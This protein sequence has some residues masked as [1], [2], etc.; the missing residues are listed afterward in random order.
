METQKARTKIEQY[1]EISKAVNS[2]PNFEML[3]GTGKTIYYRVILPESPEP[4]WILQRRSNT[5][6][7]TIWTTCLTGGANDLVNLFD[8][9]NRR[10][11]INK[12]NENP[13]TWNRFVDWLRAKELSDTATYKAL[14]DFKKFMPIHCN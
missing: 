14:A 9:V 8:A 5:K 12:F 3:T 2:I 10:V 1:Q 4:T 6:P 11:K 7:Q 13:R